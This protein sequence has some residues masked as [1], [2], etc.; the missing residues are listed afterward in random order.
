MTGRRIRYALAAVAV[1]AV[2]GTTGCAAGLDTL[3]LPAP[4]L[5]GG[6]YTIT[7]TFSNALNLPTKAKV[8]LDGADVGEVESMSARDYTAVVRMR[9]RSGVRLPVG[10]TAEL[11]TATPMGDVFVA[12]TPPPAAG[13]DTPDLT[14]GGAIPQASTSAA[15]TIEE[16]LAR[17]SLLVNGGAIENVTKVANS[18][19]EEVGNRGDRLAALIQQTRALVASLAARSAQIRATLAAT[20]TLAGTLAAQD[21][22]VNDAVAAAGPALQ[23]IGDNTQGMLDLVG[24]I[25]TITGEIARF[26]SIR[27]TNDGSLMASVNQLAADLNTAA[28]DPNT[29]MT[30]LDTTLGA[31]IRVT[32]GTGAHVNIDVAQLAL[33]SS[34]D[35]NF[36]GDPGARP[37]GLVDWT[38]F[39]G[40]LEYNLALLQS[41]LTGPHR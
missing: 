33:G 24:R 22:A 18:L 40:S 28:L 36:P 21:T 6:T 29:N 31:V 3:P 30:A 26:P 15:A 27:G 8:K 1:A 39:V 12:V 20:G 35:P 23:V 13:P 34:P 41:K 4:G 11:R 5:G 14:D 19:G 32:D 16:V 37:P 10:T 38:N 17:A 2:L 7:A 9:I 25:D